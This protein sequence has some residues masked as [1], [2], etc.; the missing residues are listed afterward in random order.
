M[1]EQQFDHF[2]RRS[3][4]CWK[5]RAWR[6]ARAP[7][8]P[9]PPGWTSPWRRWRTAVRAGAAGP[10]LVASG[11]E[12]WPDGTV[13]ERYGWRHAL[14]Q[15]VVYARVPEGRR[16]RLHRRIGTREETG[17]G[18]QAGAI[19]AELAVHF[20][21]GQ[22]ISRAVRYLQQAAENALQ[23]YA[24]QEAVAYLTN[25]LGAA[26]HP[27][28]DPGAGP[29]GARPAAGPGAGVDGHQGL[30]GPGGGADLCP[31][32][33]VVRAGRRDAPALP[34]AAGLMA[35]L[36]A[37]GGRCRRRGSWGNSSTGWRSV[38][39]TRAPPGGP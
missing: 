21:R 3:S 20:E 1:I 14:Y 4:G 17:Y 23:R 12:A 34:D 22:D 16:L 27:A 2:A 8:P 13:T 30:G 18:A 31:G 19:A 38:R 33:G 11:I 26:R 10:V 25:G 36:S 35:V 5:W 28:R 7:W 32:A 9:W 6:A 24:Y 29:A 15:E 39:P 37:T